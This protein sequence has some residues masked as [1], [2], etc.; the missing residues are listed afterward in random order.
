MVYYNSI[1][2]NKGLSFKEGQAQSRL[3][4][5]GKLRQDDNLGRENEFWEAHPLASSDKNAQR[6][7]RAGL[8]QKA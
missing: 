3:A 5:P 1:K 4:W 8:K 2:D 6:K 7:G